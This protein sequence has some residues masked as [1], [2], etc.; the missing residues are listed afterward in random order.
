MAQP[1]EALRCEQPDSG[2][3]VVLTWTV[4]ADAS[5]RVMQ[6]KAVVYSILSQ[7]PIYQL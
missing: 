6:C 5:Q 2:L 4:M 7:A 1:D 3:L